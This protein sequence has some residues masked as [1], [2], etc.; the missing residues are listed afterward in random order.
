MHSLLF[1]AT[2]SEKFEAFFEGQQ[3]LWQD[4]LIDFMDEKTNQI[5]KLHIKNNFGILL[6]SQSHE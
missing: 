4:R 5:Q 1:Q 6:A 3:K 2:S